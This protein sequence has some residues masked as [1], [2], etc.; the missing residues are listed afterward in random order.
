MLPPAVSCGGCALARRSRSAGRASLH[1]ARTHHAARGRDRVVAGSGLG[2][3]LAARVLDGHSLQGAGAAGRHQAAVGAQQASVLL[4]AWQ[5][6][7]AARRHGRRRRNHPADRSLDHGQPVSAR[8]SLDQRPRSRRPGNRLDCLLPVLCT[9]LQRTVPAASGRV[10][11]AA[12]S[13]RRAASVDRALHEHPSDRRGGGARCRR[14]VSGV[15]SR[16]ALAGT[17]SGD[18]R[19]G[20]RRAGQPRRHPRRTERRLPPLLP[21]PVLPRRGAARGQRAFVLRADAGFDGTHDERADEPA[22]S[23][24]ERAVV[25]RRRRCE[26]SLGPRRRARRLPRPA[27]ARGGA[28]SA[29]GFQGAR[30]GPG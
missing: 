30:P 18:P 25:R 2:P 19:A 24:W 26:G 23:R 6:R 3:R 7:M 22:L 27:R 17:R 5:G 15:E 11:V 9:G 8:H 20:D 4:H 10:A 29:S 16:C 1:A 21:R 12:L 28:V 14:A 13:V